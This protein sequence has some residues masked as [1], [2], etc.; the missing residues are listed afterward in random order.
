VSIQEISSF[1]ILVPLAIAGTKLRTGDLKLRL[2]FLFLLFGAVVDGIG[3]ASYKA[4]EIWK[5]HGYLLA[6]YLVYEA[7]FFLWIASFNFELG[8]RTRIRNSIGVVFILLF[9]TK[10]YFDFFEGNILYSS[11]IQMFILIVISFIL[12]FSLLRMAE[13][14][15]DILSY[16]WFWILAGIFLY[17]FGTFFIDALLYS[18]IID[19]IWYT[20]NIINIIQYGFFVVGLLLLPRS[21]RA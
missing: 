8:I 9:L 20:R 2:F 19:R 13:Q 14:R 4:N 15:D 6:F 10:F 18:Q 5:I 12:G 3:F 11:I 1:S 17:S 7:F 21:P 16:P